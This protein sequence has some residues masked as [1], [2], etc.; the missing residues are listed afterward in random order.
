MRGWSRSRTLARTYEV[1]A[2]VT[3]CDG[4]GEGELHVT[5]VGGPARVFFAGRRAATP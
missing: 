1:F 3:G 2:K 4:E 5:S